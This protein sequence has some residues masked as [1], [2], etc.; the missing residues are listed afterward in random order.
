VQ[1][2]FNVV[3]RWY[4]DFKG[5]YT[6]GSDAVTK[7]YSKADDHPFS[8]MA[9]TINQCSDTIVRNFHIY[10]NVAFAGRDTV[11]A[12]DQPV[13]LDAN[14][15]AGT[16]YLWQPATGLNSDTV[17]N[18]VATYNREVLYRLNSVTK[19]GCVSNSKILIKRYVGPALYIATAFSPNKDR[20][21]DVLHVFPVG[22]K[23]F[24]HFSIYNRAGNLIFRTTSVSKGWD[25]TY[26]GLLL[27]NQT[28][29]VF[30]EAIDYRGNP[31]MYKG[32][33]E[34]IK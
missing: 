30:A 27:E 29:S 17:E 15:Y 18:P 33:V 1:D 11:A 31:L 12:N 23:L 16:T 13:D 19:E 6:Q 3:N 34:L 7:I 28:F 26:N 21:N 9:N 20:V 24:R 25:G 22:I 4:W 5:G 8:V 10:D 2:S 14:G 32:T